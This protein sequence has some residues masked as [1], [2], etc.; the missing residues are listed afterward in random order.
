[1]QS[2]SS[3]TSIPPSLSFSPSLRS[4]VVSVNVKDH[5]YLLNLF[6]AITD[7]GRIGYAFW[8]L[9]MKSKLR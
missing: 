9:I 4:L 1:M 6:V 5:V 3:P 7:K 2:P 8:A